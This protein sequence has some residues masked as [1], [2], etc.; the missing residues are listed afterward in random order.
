ME[1]VNFLS[2]EIR[3]VNPPCRTKVDLTCIVEVA[4]IIKT[5]LAQGLN[6]QTWTPVKSVEASAET[7]GHWM[8]N[9]DRGSI[10]T[11]TVVYA[12]NAYTSALLPSFKSYIKPTAHMCNK[13]VP[14]PSWSGTKS[15]QNSY[16][17]L[18][19]NDALFSINPRANADGVVLFGGSNPAQGKL[20]EYLSGSFSRLYDDSLSN[21]EPVTNAVKEFTAAEFEGWGEEPPA[22]GQGCVYAWSGIIGLVSRFLSVET[23]GVTRNLM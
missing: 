3:Y 2:M 23:D 8:V 7:A 6:L 22:P 17:I 11:P 12:T 5:C 20:K 21:F 15:L 19:S 14:P 1:G 13:V 4:H 18:A 9:T 10:S 16:G